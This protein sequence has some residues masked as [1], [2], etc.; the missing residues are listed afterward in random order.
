MKIL[1]ILDN[2]YPHIGGAELLFQRLAEGLV[3][4]GMSVTVLVPKNYPDYLD[5][6][7]HNGVHII[8]Q[9]VPSF[10]QRYFFMVLAI[11]R[12][13]RLANQHDVI[14]TATY[15][16]IVPAWIARKLTGKKA[17][18]TVYE[19]W[20]TKWYT[21]SGQSRWKAGLFRLFERLLLTFP[22]DRIVCI[23]DSTLRD[24]VRLFPS[25]PVSRIYPGVDYDD[26]EKNRLSDEQRAVFR[27]EK[28][29]SADDFLVIGFG[30][31]GISKGFDYLVD[32]VPPVLKTQS[33]VRFLFIWPSA[34]NFISLRD[35]L[36]QRLDRFRAGPAVRVLDKQ[37]R[38]DLLQ[39]IQAADCV[40]VPSLA[41]GF[42]YAAVEACMLGR[43][44]VSTTAGS[45]PEVI[46]GHYRLVQPGDSDALAAAIV[47]MVHQ[48]SHYSPPRYFENETMIDQYQALLRAEIPS[49]SR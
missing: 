22:F 4:R 20:D 32:A 2:Y 28:G 25:A 49:V 29:Y 27:Q 12:A 42:G 39:Y 44:V 34:P 8:R 23:S 19:V 6:E 13:V 9:K 24:Y 21:L 40:V 15:N 43:S 7:T 41:E 26:F 31:P 1:Y 18:L 35:S 46:S 47:D 30:R 33:N 37:S 16:A 38:T 11:V 45:I 5:E 17:I 10:A 3:R 36:V 14:Q 48:R